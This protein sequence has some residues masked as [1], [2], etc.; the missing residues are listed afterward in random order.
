MF[1]TL[2]RD[3]LDKFQNNFTRFYPLTRGHGTL[4]SIFLL[5]KGKVKLA[6]LYKTVSYIC[7][8]FKTKILILENCFFN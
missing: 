1:F 6:T 7:F 5:Q 2:L 3:W 8:I 4:V